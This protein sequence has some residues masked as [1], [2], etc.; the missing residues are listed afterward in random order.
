MGSISTGLLTRLVERSDKAS[1]RQL[2]RLIIEGVVEAPKQ[3]RF[4]P[5][6]MLAFAANDGDRKAGW[7]LC[8]YFLEGATGIERDFEASC[9][10]R[11]RTEKRLFSDTH[12]L[13]SDPALEHEAKALYSAWRSWLALHWPVE[14]SA[15]L[16][17]PNARIG[18]SPGR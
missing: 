4:K 10:W 14:C 2:A 1:M 5:T 7:L 6:H 3:M 13:Y 9:R 15:V 18:E 12:L 11:A 17:T 8:K 16:N